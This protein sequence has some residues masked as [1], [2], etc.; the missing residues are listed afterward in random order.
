MSKNNVIK[1]ELKVIAASEDK[2][3]KNAKTI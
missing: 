1:K 2:A 3:P